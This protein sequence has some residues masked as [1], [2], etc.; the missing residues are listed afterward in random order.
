MT[1]TTKV[2]HNLQ[3]GVK[4]ADDLRVRGPINDALNW[5]GKGLV[6][7]LNTH[8]GAI[9]TSISAA[10]ATFLATANTWTAPQTISVATA[11]TILTLLSTEAGAGPGPTVRLA[12]D[13][14]TPAAADFIGSVDFDGRGLSNTSTQYGRIIAQIVDTVAGAEDGLLFIQTRAAGATVNSII[15]GGAGGGVRIGPATGGDMGAGTL[16]LDS[17]LYRD[18]TQILSVR[19]TGYGDPF[20]AISRATFSVTTVTTASLAGFVAALFTD[21]KAHG[22]IGN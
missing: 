6:D 20:G 22:L 7:E 11:G 18:G 9:S 12:R 14:A 4:A 1:I 19:V 2:F 8:F 13:S 5:L 10:L 21:L 3:T 15:A 16:N 17:G